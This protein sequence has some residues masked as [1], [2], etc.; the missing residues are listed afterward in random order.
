MEKLFLIKK[1]KMK[2]YVCVWD[3]GLYSIERISKGFGG[4]VAIFENLEDLKKYANENN[5]KIA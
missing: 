2:F 4:T 1:G 3:C 5:Y